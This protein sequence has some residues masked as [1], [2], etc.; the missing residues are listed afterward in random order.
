MAAPLVI[1][2]LIA[3][4]GWRG[5]STLSIVAVGALATLLTPG[6]GQAGL[7]FR[8]I[9]GYPDL[10]VLASGFLLLALSRAVEAH[11]GDGPPAAP[12]HTAV[13]LF[14]AAIASLP[15]AIGFNPFARGRHVSLAMLFPFGLPILLIGHV[16]E[17]AIMPQASMMLAPFLLLLAFCVLRPHGPEPYA[18]E[19]S[20]PASVQA[21]PVIGLLF[22]TASGTATWTEALA[23]GAAA[24]CVLAWRGAGA[25]AV[26]RS[27]ARAASDAGLL[28]SIAIFVLA[29]QYAV[30]SRQI[31]SSGLLDWALAGGWGG[32]WLLAAAA[33]LGA[34]AGTTL[35][36]MI[37]F[38]MI[39]VPVMVMTGFDITATIVPV[40]L[41][42]ECGRY[43]RATAQG[44]DDGETPDREWVLALAALA[45][46]SF[47]FSEAMQS[48]SAILG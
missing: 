14:V 28:A 38:P 9:P 8:Y 39:L 44:S 16:S 40:L 25:G 31:Y 34:L 32:L 27:Q 35:S 12:S 23:L 22:L 48:F 3:F 43:L 41:A 33:L 20:R 36:V 45:L 17:S 19:P 13:A 6:V 46:A 42:A 21:L 37:L 15:K 47:F 4:L 5:F 24:A 10:Y 18:G 2:A 29:I 1:V 7:L 26:L 11:R 30:A